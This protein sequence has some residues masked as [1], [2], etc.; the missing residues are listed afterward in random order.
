MPSFNLKKFRLS[1]TKLSQ[2]EFASKVKSS[3][4]TISNVEAGLQNVTDNL[5]NKIQDAFDVDLEPYKSYNI[6]SVEDSSGE[7]IET[8][9]EQLQKKYLSILEEKVKLLRKY[10]TLLERYGMVIEAHS[11]LKEQFYQCEKTKVQLS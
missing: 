6:I 4:S 11:T 3:R 7:H 5:L 9:L 2:Q 1:H 8:N 10:S